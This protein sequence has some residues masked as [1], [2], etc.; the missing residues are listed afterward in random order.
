MADLKE[1][2]IS[3]LSSTASCNLAATAAT[4]LALYT[5]PTGKTA[6]IHSVVMRTFSA[7]P[8]TAVVTF[9]HTG[10]TCEEWSGDVTLTGITASYAEQ[11]LILQP[12]PATTPLAKSMFTA[13]EIFGM[14]ITTAGAASTCTI[15]VLG[16]LF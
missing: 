9:G 3:L 2:S 7:D 10:G 11:V 1:K 5:V 4:E 12:V 6:I 16:Y 13:A 8:T 14:E 15:D